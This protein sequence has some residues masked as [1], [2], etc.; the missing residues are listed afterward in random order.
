MRFGIGTLLPVV[1]GAALAGPSLH[2]AM[3]DPPLPRYVLAGEA[4]P[5]D[6][7]AGDTGS[8]SGSDP[9][10]NGTID[11]SIPDNQ[12]DTGCDKGDTSDSASPAQPA[13]GPAPA[14]QPTR[15]TPLRGSDTDTGRVPRGG[16]ST[17]GGGTAR[18]F[19]R[20]GVLASTA[21]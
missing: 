8:G 4:D 16:V 13:P 14:P 17:G 3:H 9:S 18:R 21:R 12:D 2:A 6:D 1:L 19:Y 20:A 7:Q 10:E 5:S 15:T 11:C